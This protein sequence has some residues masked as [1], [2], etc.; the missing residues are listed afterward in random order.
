MRKLRSRKPPSLG[1]S[2]KFKQA[3]ALCDVVPFMLCSCACCSAAERLQQRQLVGACCLSQSTPVPR[4]MPVWATTRG[5]PRS[6]QSTVCSFLGTRHADRQVALPCVVCEGACRTLIVCQ[7]YVVCYH[8]HMPA[9]WHTPR[10]SIPQSM[11]W[12]FA[13]G[14]HI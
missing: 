9:S 10:H 7:G 12:M 5:A 11:Q 1:A 4:H 14:L 2:L 8:T 13:M 6:E 3:K